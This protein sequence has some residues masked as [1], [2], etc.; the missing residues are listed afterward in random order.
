MIENDGTSTATV[1][2]QDLQV[3][4]FYKAAKARFYEE[5]DNARV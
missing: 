4:G 1:P 3:A 5:D 2:D